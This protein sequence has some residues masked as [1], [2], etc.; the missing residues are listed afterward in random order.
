[1]ANGGDVLFTASKDGTVRQLNVLDNFACE[2][3]FS[4]GCAVSSLATRGTHVLVGS[5]DGRV[6]ELVRRKAGPRRVRVLN[7]GIA[8]P[9]E[10]LDADQP[11]PGARV[12]ALAG[13]RLAVWLDPPRRL[14]GAEEGEEVPGPEPDGTWSSP[15]ASAVVLVPG[16][17]EDYIFAGPSGLGHGSGLGARDWAV[18]AA[19]VSGLLTALVH[20]CGAGGASVAFAAPDPQ[21][22]NP[23][24]AVLFEVAV[25][26][27]EVGVAEIGSA[28]GVDCSGSSVSG[29]GGTAARAEAAGRGLPT[30]S[31]PTSTPPVA[32]VATGGSPAPHTAA[33]DSA[34]QDG[35]EH[36]RPVRKH[37][38]S[39]TTYFHP[40]AASRG[41]QAP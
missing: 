35:A 5:A 27:V 31:A 28:A 15:G 12:L 29:D 37:R 21:S 14:A 30:T 8:A 34:P 18:A 19:K 23:K 2:D 25:P 38:A 11:G 32:A 16:G 33:D 9:V 10:S 3:F 39:D 1:M 4:A 17:K 22:R 13:G 7:L 20:V 40:T 26:P 36:E 6:W 24:H 41:R